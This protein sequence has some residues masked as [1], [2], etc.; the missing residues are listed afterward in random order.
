MQSCRSSLIS[1]N[2]G[3]RRAELRRVREFK[4]GR[5]K[6]N[7]HDQA[8]SDACMREMS[9]R[10]GQNDRQIE[11]IKKESIKKDAQAKQ[12]S[13]DQNSAGLP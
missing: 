3:Q 8:H 6:I 11:S 9:A 2:S 4:R 1:A 12:T 10:N 13:A 7:A 5:T